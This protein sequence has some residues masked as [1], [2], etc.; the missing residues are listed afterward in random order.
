ME[1]FQ[2]QYANIQAVFK[3]H[4]SPHRLQ[5]PNSPLP[6][7]ITYPNFAQYVAG[8]I[9]ATGLPDGSKIKAADNSYNPSS[10]VAQ[11]QTGTQ[12]GGIAAAASTSGSG[13]AAGATSTMSGG[14]TKESQT[15]SKSGAIANNGFGSVLVAGSLAAG[16]LLS[17]I[18]MLA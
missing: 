13:S 1:E 9:N 3:T 16:V 4:C 7:D 5:E 14:A 10:A 12:T 18:V 15:S 11:T 17:A 8:N 2:K 6:E